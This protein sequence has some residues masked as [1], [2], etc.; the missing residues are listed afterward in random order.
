MTS[1]I[2]PQTLVWR[3]RRAKGQCTRCEQILEKGSLQADC[4][5]CL[6]KRRATSLRLRSLRL[7]KGTCGKCGKRPPVDGLVSCESCRGASRQR[8]RK[9]VLGEHSEE[10]QRLTITFPLRF[11]PTACAICSR[12]PLASQALSLDHCHQTGQLRGLLCSS[13]NSALGLF[14]D[15]ENV[16]RT[17]IT[18]LKLS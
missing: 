4:S 1:Q 17:A 8:A 18:Y 11:N 15:N 16:L 2:L 5:D 12:P 13:C 7:S 14:Q 10:L 9:C 6:S 3:A